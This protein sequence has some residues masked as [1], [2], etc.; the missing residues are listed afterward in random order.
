MMTPTSAATLTYE[1]RMGSKYADCPVCGGESTLIC[2]KTALEKRDALEVNEWFDRRLKEGCSILCDGIHIDPI[3]LL[4]RGHRICIRCLFVTS[5]QNEEELEWILTSGAIEALRTDEAKR[6]DVLRTILKTS[7]GEGSLSVLD[8][9]GRLNR[10][11]ADR[12]I[13]TKHG[14][15][16]FENPQF[17]QALVKLCLQYLTT[18]DHAEVFTDVV[19]N[20]FTNGVQSLMEV[21]FALPIARELIMVTFDIDCACLVRTIVTNNQ[22]PFIPQKMLPDLGDANRLRAAF[23]EKRKGRLIRSHLL[24]AVMAN[25]LNLSELVN[26]EN[27]NEILEMALVFAELSMQHENRQFLTEQ[28]KE[29][30]RKKAGD[31]ARIAQLQKGTNQAKEN[32]PKKPAENPRGKVEIDPRRL[33]HNREILSCII[34]KLQSLLGR[35][36]DEK[37]RDRAIRAVKTHE[38]Y[39]FRG[40]CASIGARLD[41]LLQELH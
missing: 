37:L 19:S 32:M 36:L 9:E 7:P 11:T 25:L 33:P 17:R 31:A 10:K 2:R 39:S 20:V 1:A 29:T 18:P 8:L 38:V 5:I 34:L 30:E 35:P 40:P 23:E 27:R 28:D 22:F 13:F 26:E 24:F 14:R 41:S 4:V 12:R 21:V 6:L 3:N 16:H 15:K